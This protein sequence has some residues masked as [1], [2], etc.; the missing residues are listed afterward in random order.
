MLLCSL[1]P[2]CKGQKSRHLLHRQHLA[3]PSIIIPRR[4]ALIIMLVIRAKW[5][6]GG[7]RRCRPTSLTIRRPTSRICIPRRPWL[8]IQSASK[9][10]GKPMRVIISCPTS[11][12]LCRYTTPCRHSTRIII[13]RRKALIIMAVILRCPTTRM[14]RRLTTLIMQVRKRFAPGLKLRVYPLRSHSHSTLNVH[15]VLCSHYTNRRA[16]DRLQIY[17]L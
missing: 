7:R 6:G 13:P 8:Q 14:I 1:I 2:H 10:D 9:N 4:S 11:R 12:T 3:S 5:W 16:R 17:L 15:T